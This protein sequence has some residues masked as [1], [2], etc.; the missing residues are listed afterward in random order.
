MTVLIFLII[1]AAGILPFFATIG[2]PILLE[3]IDPAFGRIMSFDE[4]GVRES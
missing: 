3:L 1:R 2:W 4:L